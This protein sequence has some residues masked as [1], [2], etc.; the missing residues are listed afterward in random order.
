ML[1]KSKKCL[2]HRYGR[3]HRQKHGSGIFDLLTKTI[4]RGA[5]KSMVNKLTKAVGHVINNPSIRKTIKNG[6]MKGAESAIANASDK[7]LTNLANNVG[8][9]MLTNNVNNQTNG[10]EHQTSIDNVQ[11]MLIQK[12]IKEGEK[13]TLSSLIHG[14]GWRKIKGRGI[15]LD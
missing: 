7:V 1:V 13:K 10:K 4:S 3:Q 9:K 15:V 12:P 5:S 2:H 11:E 14:S 6:V 8:E